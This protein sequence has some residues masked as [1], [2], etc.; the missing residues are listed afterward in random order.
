MVANKLHA[1]KSIHK[2]HVICSFYRYQLAKMV[3]GIILLIT[4]PVYAQVIVD[5]VDESHAKTLLPEKLING[6][7]SL[8][9][10]DED[11]ESPPQRQGKPLLYFYHQTDQ[12]LYA[13][14]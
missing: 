8:F 2:L 10:L 7:I 4:N 9:K 1:L 11:P 13:L 6:G 14:L 3:I 5:T 12:T